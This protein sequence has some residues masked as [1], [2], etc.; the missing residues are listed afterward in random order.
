MYY[1]IA[2]VTLSSEIILPSFENF[3]CDQNEADIS[4]T[5]TD[6]VPEEGSEVTSGTVVQRTIEGGWYFYIRGDNQRGLFA[7]RDYTDLQLRGCDDSPAGFSVESL[8][9]MA[10]ECCLVKRGFVSLHAACIELDGEAFAFSAPSGTGKS[11]RAGA[12]QEAFGANLIS[13]DRPLVDVNNLEVYGMP[14]DGK[15]GCY[16]NVHFPL[17]AIFDIRRSETAYIRKMNFSQR[18]KFLMRQC[19]IPMWDTETAA[20]QM[21][22]IS[23]LASNAEILRA[24]S[25]YRAEDA[26]KL[27]GEYDKGEYREAQQDM[28]AV[29]GYV[30]NDFDGELILMPD[31]R[32]TG[33]KKTAV[34][35][36]TVTAFWW[37]VLRTPMCRDDLLIAVLNE[38]DVDEEKASADLDK[39]MVKLYKLGV[40]EDD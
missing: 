34:R 23:L 14:W 22:N 33:K 12:W 17:K 8:V 39:Y 15:E 26:V 21:I 25:G 2:D 24:F 35:L 5:I 10:I 31:N 28:K 3:I 4:I 20:N 36:N 40:V 30:L 18:R 29:D 38:F 6:E 9:R 27:R 1:R 7:R 13:G 32:N 37:E 11:T 16:R 19:F